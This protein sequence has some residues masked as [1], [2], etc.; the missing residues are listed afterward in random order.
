MLCQ[1]ATKTMRSRPKLSQERVF[2]QVLDYF[3]SSNVA[4][5]WGG[6]VMI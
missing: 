1:N 2:L 5:D 3:V 6:R 4:T